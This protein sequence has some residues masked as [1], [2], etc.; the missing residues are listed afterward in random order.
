MHKKQL[1][2]ALQ[3]LAVASAVAWAPMASAIDWTV[4]GF[5][6]QEMAWKLDSGDENFWNQQ[7][8]VWN[9]KPQQNL[10]DGGTYQRFGSPF[11]PK[12]YGE[13]DNDWNLMATRGELDIEAT[14][15]PDLKFFTKIRGYF[16]WDIY[17]G[18]NDVNYFEVPFRDDCGTR[19]E[20]CDE[21]YMIDL[22]AAYLDYNNGS[23]WVRAGN[24]QI[25][26]GE[27]IFF[28]VLDVPN[29]IDLRRHSV[30][31]IA[32][33]EYADKRVPGLG[34]RASYRFKNDWEL[35]GFVQEFNPSILPNENT[36]YNVI[37]SQFVV[38]L[39][40]T[41]DD[42]DDELNY[43]IRLRGQVGELGMQFI[44]VSRRNPD[45]FYRW[46]TSKVN[47]FVK[48]GIPDPDL[49]GGLT[50]GA[51]A[52]QTPFEPFT[53]LGV[54]GNQEWFTG[55]G[56]SRLNGVDGVQSSID[57]FPASQA[58]AWG[59]GGAVDLCTG[60]PQ[61]TVDTVAEA[62]CVLDAFFS[63]VAGFGDLRGHIER[64]YKREEIFGF[65]F[66]YIF[67]AEPDSFLD[68][69]VVRF[70]A[71]YTP[72]KEFTDISL[73]QKPNEQDEY[74]T[75]L[76]FEKYHRFSQEFP[77]TFLVFQW[78]HKS[79]S[80]LFGRH[81]D[82]Y[83]AEDLNSP[84][85]GRD[86]FNALAFALQQPF[87][88]LIWRADLAILYDTEGGYLIQPGLRWKPSRSFTVEAFANIVDGSNDNQ[89]TLSSLQWTDELALR[90]TWQF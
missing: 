3:G 44:A 6:R 38:Q 34:L 5:L 4:S 35:E 77:A 2:R 21:D 87:P 8:I 64:V 26:W 11:T 67:F 39:E 84:P 73:R 80:D 29:G 79:E 47:P 42:V 32:A 36:P 60:D 56:N 28:R 75:G 12:S 15:N 69:L 49:G 16:D 50:L 63:P 85:Q 58:L 66:N 62:Q 18:P 33:E 24:Q 14:F 81:L 65:G 43:G 27:S 86:N 19:L 76:V 78:M 10:V 30:L 22:P 48:A 55:A 20:V 82:G 70:E 9:G 45:G 71:T 83:D 25:A 52:S 54:Y 31:D 40:D 53:G 17:D 46:T 1:T 57:E 13:E 74:V 61:G 89:D 51:L 59:P 41:F 72:D 23:L 68:Q 7:G 90:L 37:A 88:N